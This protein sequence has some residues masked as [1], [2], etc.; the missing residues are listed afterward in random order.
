MLALWIFLTVP[1]NLGNMP[2]PDVSDV[3]AATWAVMT[4][5]KPFIAIILGITLAITLVRTFTSLGS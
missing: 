3:I 5:F 1:D 4:P 2:F